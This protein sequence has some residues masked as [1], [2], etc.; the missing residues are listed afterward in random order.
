MTF[1]SRLHLFRVFAQIRFSTWRLKRA[2]RRLERRTNQKESL[3][4]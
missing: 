3:V 4:V 1:L 2:L